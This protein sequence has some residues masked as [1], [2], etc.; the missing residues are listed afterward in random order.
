MP[1]SPTVQ[2]R[3]T[4]FVYEL[5]KQQADVESR[6]VSNMAAFLLEVELRGDYLLS[7]I[8]A[9]RNSRRA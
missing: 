7:D 9:G 5:L 2:V 8:R 1:S 3:L 4:P 6:S